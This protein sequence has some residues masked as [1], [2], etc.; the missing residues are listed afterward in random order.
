MA[1]RPLIDHVAT[2]DARI[3]QTQPM[4]IR[5]E[6][7]TIDIDERIQYD[8]EANTLRLNFKG[9]EI[10]SVDDIEIIRKVAEDKCR[11]AGKKVKA[12]V[13]YESF[14]IGEDLLDAYLEMGKYIIETYYQ[15]VTRHTT[16]EKMRSKLGDELV[17]RGLVPSLYETEEEAET[18]IL[19]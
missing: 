17:K 12:I 5:P 3:F 8:P 11:A 16:S 19:I 1:F 9:L 15:D 4:G 6:L 2:M 7:L 18:R 14:S 13:D 10:E